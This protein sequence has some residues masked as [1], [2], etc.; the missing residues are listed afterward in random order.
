MTGSSRCVSP[1][2]TATP[3]S[4]RLVLTL[5]STATSS[6]APVDNCPNQPNHGQLDVDGDG[7]GDVCDSTPGFELEGLA[8]TCNGRAATI[9]GTQGD[10]VLTGTSGVDVI[11]G[12]GGNDSI[13]GL[14]GAD[15]LCG[16]SG[17]DRVFGG[18]GNDQ[19][20]GENGNDILEGG[21]NNDTVQG[22]SGNDI[23]RG[24][25]GDDRLSDILGN[26]NFSG[27]PGTDWC[28]GSREGP[29]SG[30]EVVAVIR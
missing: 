11:I 15:V 28:G 12:L 23:M 7:I 25:K 29:Y 30:C 10:N 6:D 1:T 26:D 24:E 4:R 14:D 13:S 20:F 18:R 9:V 3:R 22:G 5:R 19:L 8:A 2:T 16:G 21:D 17:N 27:G